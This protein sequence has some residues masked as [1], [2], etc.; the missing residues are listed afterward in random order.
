V[1]FLPFS[2]NL[3]VKL[4]HKRDFQNFRDFSN[5]FAL[6]NGNLLAKVLRSVTKVEGGGQALM[7]QLIATLVFWTVCV[8]GE[9]WGR[10]S[11]TSIKENQIFDVRKNKRFS[12]EKINFDFQINFSKAQQLLR[13]QFEKRN[14]GAGESRKAVV[15]GNVFNETFQTSGPEVPV[16]LCLLVDSA[17]RP[18]T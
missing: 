3:L 2:Q 14:I 13:K 15:R 6:L 1:D 16:V 8:M 11:V 17:F 9:G 12:Y 5:F 4:A 10:E 18:S 7:L